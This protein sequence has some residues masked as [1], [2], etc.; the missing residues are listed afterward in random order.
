MDEREFQYYLHFRAADIQ[1]RAARERLV[2]AILKQ[3][4]RE[5]RE[6]RRRTLQI[7]AEGLIDL[8]LILA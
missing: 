5:Q 7:L 4:R 2:H 1:R 8:L 3:K 6:T